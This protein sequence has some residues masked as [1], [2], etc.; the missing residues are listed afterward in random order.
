MDLLIVKKKI[1]I[2]ELKNNQDLQEKLVKTLDNINKA[3]EE[4]K[5]MSYDSD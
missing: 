5:N 2:E 4:L 3:I 1:I